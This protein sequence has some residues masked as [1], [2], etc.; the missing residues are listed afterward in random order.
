MSKQ[1]REAVP[2]YLLWMELVQSPIYSNGDLQ[3]LHTS[4]F[5]LLL[6]NSC[7]SCPTELG[8]SF[9]NSSTHLFHNDAVIARAVQ[10]KLLQNSPDLQEGKPVAAQRETQTA[11]RHQGQL[12]QA[13]K[14]RS[15]SWEP[16]MI[17][18]TWD[19]FAN[20]NTLQFFKADSSL[21]SDWKL[22]PDM[23]FAMLDCISRGHEQ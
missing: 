18:R 3:V 9:W 19:H 10:A 16:A 7:Q 4:V 20:S 11:A 2:R 8:S 15:Y 1:Q 5:S 14:Q 17:H 13:H 23:P 6:Y 12:Q 21:N 22:T